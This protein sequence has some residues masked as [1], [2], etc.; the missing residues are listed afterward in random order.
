MALHHSPKSWNID[1]ESLQL[2]R[3]VGW[4]VPGTVCS[5]PAATP[6]VLS[7]GHYCGVSDG[8]ISLDVQTQ[9][10]GKFNVNDSASW[11][12]RW[13]FLSKGTWKHSYLSNKQKNGRNSQKLSHDT[14]LHVRF[15]LCSGA[16][17]LNP[18]DACMHAPHLP[19]GASDSK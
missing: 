5:I 12:E 1:G 17:R 6:F 9:A 18:T 3:V 4:K 10:I 2:P 7:V 19:Y 14:L 8:S 16:G 13:P 15:Q 11:R